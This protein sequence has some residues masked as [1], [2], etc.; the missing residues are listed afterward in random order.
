M[1][2]FAFRHKHSE[3]NSGCGIS[4][5]KPSYLLVQVFHQQ[6]IYDN[7][8]SKWP[9]NY[10]VTTESEKAYITFWSIS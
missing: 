4:N 7:Q 9:P 3:K 2:I 8:L 6:C 10:I 1:S 5:G